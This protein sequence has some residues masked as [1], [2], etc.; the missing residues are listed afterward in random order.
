MSSEDMRDI[1]GSVLYT[2]GGIDPQLIKPYILANQIKLNSIDPITLKQF[3]DNLVCENIT[4]KV[5]FEDLK[6][7]VNEVYYKRGVSY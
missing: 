5:Q 3:I 7:K 6:N 2:A 1:I 4:L